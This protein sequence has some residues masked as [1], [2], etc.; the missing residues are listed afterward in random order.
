MSAVYSD[1]RPRVLSNLWWGRS[2]NEP[3]IG[4]GPYGRVRVSENNFAMRWEV[5]LQWMKFRVG[6]YDVSS[7]KE[8]LRGS[9]LTHLETIPRAPLPRL[10]RGTNTH[11]LGEK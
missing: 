10:R 3:D 4:E 6:F 9:R 11:K 8:K 5:S 1:Q 7:T 2:N